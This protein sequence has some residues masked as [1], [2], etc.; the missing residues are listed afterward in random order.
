MTMWVSASV[1]KKI[2][3]YDMN[4]EVSGNSD[5]S[6]DSTLIVLRLSGIRLNPTFS[7]DKE[8]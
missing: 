7:P 3:A 1:D 5:V 6:N 8:I 4:A 2:Y